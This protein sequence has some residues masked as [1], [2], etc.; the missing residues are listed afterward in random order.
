M[1]RCKTSHEVPT[2]AGKSFFAG[3]FAH[4]RFYYCRTRYALKLQAVKN[5]EK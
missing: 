1:I 4:I 2:E 3:L 5:S